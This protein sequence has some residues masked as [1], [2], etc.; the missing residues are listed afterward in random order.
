MGVS[1]S[2][3][4]PRRM[5]SGHEFDAWFVYAA[6][7]PTGHDDVLIKFGISTVPY[8]RLYA[9]NCNS[10]YPIDL[11]FFCMAGRKRVA[12][13]IE[14]EVL[15]EFSEFK[16]R[17]EWLRLRNDQET[18]GRFASAVRTTFFELTGRAPEWRK[19][20]GQQIREAGNAK[21]GEHF[22]RLPKT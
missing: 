8:D 7:C 11:A 22:L 19:A 14:R 21:L 2:N 15:T 9:I 18:R 13:S 3:P 17:G 1:W 20:T 10:P 16:T 4:K 12:L 6:L 5:R